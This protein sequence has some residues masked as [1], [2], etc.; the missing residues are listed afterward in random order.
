MFTI[1]VGGVSGFRLEAPDKSRGFV[2]ESVDWFQLRDEFGDFR[3][4]Q[5]R[6]QGCNVN[7]RQMVVHGG[8]QGTLFQRP[9]RNRNGSRESSSQA[10]DPSRA[11]RP[12]PAQN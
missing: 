8:L 12:R 9:F 6:N 3:V 5:R 2:L 10:S 7:L 4:L 11:S 1:D